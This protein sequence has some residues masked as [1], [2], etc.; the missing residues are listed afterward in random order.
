MRH[1]DLGGV[2]EI[3]RLSF[4]EPWSRAQFERE[5]SNPVSCQFVASVDAESGG[6][7]AGYIIFWIVY[8]EA[9]IL[10]I[11]VHPAFRRRGIAKELLSHSLD[12]MRFVGVSEVYLEVRRSNE[13]ALSLYR[14]FG[15]EKVFVRRNYYGDEDA[16]VM[17]LRLSKRWR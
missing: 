3:E 1:G 15:F 8:G 16:V 5:L 9:H 17:R 10:N 11:A 13:A 14:G 6:I 2:L 12:H 7:V 4:P